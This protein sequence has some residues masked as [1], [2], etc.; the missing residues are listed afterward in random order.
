MK[1]SA[2]LALGIVVAAIGAALI[3]SKPWI[4]IHQTKPI[5]VKGYAEKTVMSDTGSMSVNVQVSASDYSQAYG[6]AGKSLE[7]IKLIASECLGKPADLVE[8]GTNINPV[9]KLDK[10]GAK[11]NQVDHYVVTRELRIN[12]SNVMALK[13]L[14]R[15]LYDLNG[16][17]IRVSIGGPAFFISNLDNVKLSLIEQATANGKKRAEIMAKNSGANL[18]EL[19]AARQGVIQITKK[20]SSDTS[21]W[22]IYDTETIEK[23]V[24]LVVTLEYEIKN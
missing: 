5:R 12:T 7:K 15:K 20:N 16:N 17:G 1:N 8:L 22:G 24:K 13:K 3:V 18:G 19:V 14:E 4:T 21:D 2:P 6:E 10:N 23:V 9:P 11:T